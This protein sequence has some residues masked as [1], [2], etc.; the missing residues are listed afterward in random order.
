MALTTPGSKHIPFRNSKLTLI[1]KESLGGNSKTTLLCTASRQKRHSEES[2]Q[3]L[4]FASR[5]KAIKNNCKSN[6]QLGVKELQYLVDN[7]RKE[8]LTLRG[9]LKKGG[10]TFNPII[11]SKLLAIIRNNEWEL[12]GEEISR[13]II[14]HEDPRAK[15]ASLIHLNE[16]EIILKY[17]ELRAKYDNLLEAAGNKIY[18]LSNQAKAEIDH[19]LISDIKNE[20]DQ[21]LQE[22]IEEKTKEINS[23]Q[24]QMEKYKRL[25]E[26]KED[27]F[28]H[29]IQDLSKDKYVRDEEYDTLTKELESLRELLNLAYGEI[30]QL[31]EKLEKKKKKSSLLKE[32]NKNLKNDVA[33]YLSLIEELNKKISESELKSLD[34]KQKLDDI[35]NR[36]DLV[37][38]EVENL[39][40]LLKQKGEN[41]DFQ[42]NKIK[43]LNDEINNYLESISITEKK[44][45]DLSNKLSELE[46]RFK[47][48]TEAFNSKDLFNQSLIEQLK[49]ENTNLNNAI[50]DKVSGQ[51]IFAEREKILSS[52]KANLEKRIED[53][54][55]ENERIKSELSDTFTKVNSEKSELVLQLDNLSRELK[56][57]TSELENALYELEN[58]K[59]TFEEK[60][61]SESQKVEQLNS[62]I[63]VSEKKRNELESTN[64]NL[65]E[66]EKKLSAEK[67][68]LEKELKDKS[69]AYEEQKELASKYLNQNEK[70]EKEIKE[71]REALA[72][73]Q[74][75]NKEDSENEKKLTGEIA[76]LK[77]DL[78]FQS[79]RVTDTE[80]KN[81]EVK[82]EKKVLQELNQNL[83]NVRNNYLLIN[84]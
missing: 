60:L 35:N 27:E 79:K 38:I 64:L 54:L 65:T 10:L 84:F 73:S 80:K 16:Q 83:S 77:K 20:T 59:K 32:E 34:H 61:K 5:A 78:E 66:S 13:D 9:Q 46:L 31:K 29:K 26:T 1:L 45:S 17:C 42:K 23:S 50:Q 21:K 58:L 67:T 47:S 56:S 36:Y 48:E 40:N 81:E 70:L 18:Q 3:T 76:L 2:V 37:Q 14:N 41:E 74:N 44:Y 75:R 57:K 33:N 8:I 63:E 19:N 39:N 4:Y 72:E 68:Q 30:Q 22:I 12:D 28:N 52:A 53:V 7:M 25:L 69:A 49:Q 55:A 43:D 6:I 82:N 11:D 51:E 71:L 24:E 15:R 62:R